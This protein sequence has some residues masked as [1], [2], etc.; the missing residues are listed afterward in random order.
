MMHEKYR[1]SPGVGTR[2][3]FVRLFYSLQYRRYFG[4][5]FLRKA[6]TSLLRSPATLK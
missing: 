5:D 6:C 4:A 3:G 2:V 1:C